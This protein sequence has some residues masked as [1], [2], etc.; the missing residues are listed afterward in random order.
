MDEM[1]V[2]DLARRFVTGLPAALA[3]MRTELEANFRATLQ[4]A[5][6]R[7]DLASRSEFDVQTKVLERARE[8]IAALETR[9]AALEE[10]LRLLQDSL[11]PVSD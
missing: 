3:N 7:F 2:E 8:R 9:I 4:G 1:H 10:R 6:S 11:P 5:A